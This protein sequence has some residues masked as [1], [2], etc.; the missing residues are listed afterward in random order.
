MFVKCV[1]V[2]KA[3]HKP[4]YHR[5]PAVSGR[6]SLYFWKQARVLRVHIKVAQAASSRLLLPE[7]KPISS[8]CIFEKLMSH[9]TDWR[10]G[11]E[12]HL[13]LIYWFRRKL[14]TIVEKIQSPSMAGVFKVQTDAFRLAD[15][16]NQIRHPCLDNGC[17]IQPHLLFC[18]NTVMNNNLKWKCL[19]QSNYSECFPK[20]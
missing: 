17:T 6:I 4:G 18:T 16:S 7:P 3:W 5:D 11:I 1:F 13:A 12:V 19:P 9:W 2:H 8:V 14:R 15:N 20:F 10:H